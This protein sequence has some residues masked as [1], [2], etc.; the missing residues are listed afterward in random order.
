MMYT[1]AYIP[2]SAPF[3]YQGGQNLFSPFLLNSN[4]PMS[5]TP[6]FFQAIP[7]FQESSPTY[8]L[9]PVESAQGNQ[10]KRSQSNNVEGKKPHTL[11]DY[12]NKLLA[13][14]KYGELPNIS[15]WNETNKKPNK[16]SSNKSSGIEGGLKKVGDS[17]VSGS[18]SKTSKESSVEFPE[19]DISKNLKKYRN[20]AG[21]SAV[22]TAEDSQIWKVQE[23]LESLDKKHA[24]FIQKLKHS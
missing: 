21:R 24:Y 6:Q 12:K 5:K 11:K 17:V 1:M 18:Y 19:E 13:D 22:S 3:N 7:Q 14:F 9:K 4:A 2:V 20:E 23:E 10:P 15:E 8:S 16:K